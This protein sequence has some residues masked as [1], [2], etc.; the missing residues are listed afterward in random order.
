[1][2]GALGVVLLIGGVE[3]LAAIQWE[4][5]MCLRKYRMMAQTFIYLARNRN[6]Y[7]TLVNTVM[8]SWVP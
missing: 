8:N 4:I 6:Y 2:G 7:R 3:E 5:R 1:V